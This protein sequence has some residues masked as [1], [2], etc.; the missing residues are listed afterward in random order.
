MPHTINT[1]NALGAKVLFVFPADEATLP[2][3]D[4]ASGT[5]VVNAIGAASYQAAS[6]GPAGVMP[7]ATDWFSTATIPTLPAAF[8]MGSFWRQSANQY[9]TIMSIVFADDNYFQLYMDPAASFGIK[10]RARSGGTAGDAGTAVLGGF[11]NWYFSAGVFASATDRKLYHHDGSTSTLSAADTTNVTP[12]GGA[13]RI[14]LG[15]L[16]TATPNS[17][18]PGFQ[19]FGVIF[20]G[21][22]T[23]AEL[24]SFV[25]DPNQIFNADSALSGDAILAGITADGSMAPLPD[26]SIAGE[27]IFAGI[28]ADGGMGLAP[29]VITTPVLKNNTGTILASVSGIVA[30]VYHPTTGV[31]VVRKTGLT[32]DGSGI[33]TISDVL[34]VPATTYA[35]EL[36]LSAS[37]QG[38]RLPTG[39]AA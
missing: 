33:V 39:V 2:Y 37:T 26:S 34:L 31:L 38:R 21:A 8:T 18:M 23:E 25:A 12:A 4:P 6:P 28:T 14:G 13:T 32:S 16:A 30:N 10:A 11:N 29:G 36:D 17:G 27:A 19:K 5:I 35:Y 22:L 3:T 15:V 20:T 1:G 9:S 7:A 24:D